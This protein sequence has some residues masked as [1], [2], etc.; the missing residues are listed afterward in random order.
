MALAPGRRLAY[1]RPLST[2]SPPISSSSSSSSALLR[3]SSTAGAAAAHGGRGE[4]GGAGA[5]G[6]GGAGGEGEGEDREGEGAGY[7][8]VVR[9]P[10]D[11]PGGVATALFNWRTGGI[12]VQP[13]ERLDVVALMAVAVAQSWHDLHLAATT[14]GTASAASAAKKKS[15]GS[16]SAKPAPVK[17]IPSKLPRRAASVGKDDRWGTCGRM[18]MVLL[19][20][21]CA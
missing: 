6:V 14:A 16:T 5:G 4:R 15:P 20:R 1:S 11:C 21:E 13:H 17:I 19:E 10:E 7:V 2:F 3:S 8:T 18:V 12:E 9:Y